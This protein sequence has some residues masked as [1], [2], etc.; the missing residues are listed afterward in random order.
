MYVVAL[1]RV[2][3]P[4]HEIQRSRTRKGEREG[5]YPVSEIERDDVAG[6]LPSRKILLG[7]HTLPDV[8]RAAAQ[9]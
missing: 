4:L 7:K 8:D 6:Y 3:M 5:G 9:K 1:R 2:G